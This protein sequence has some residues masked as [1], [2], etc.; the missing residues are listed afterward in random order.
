MHAV[1]HILPDFRR[2][3]LHPARP[4]EDLPVL[5]L[6]DGNDRRLIVEQ[7]AA[8]RGGALVDRRDKATGGRHGYWKATS[9]KL[10]SLRECR[11]SR[12]S[13]LSFSSAFSQIS[14]CWPTRCRSNS[15]AMPARLISRKETR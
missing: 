3:M 9:A 14:I 15:P 11:L 7:D 10:L 13:V 4:G 12:S 8:R 6:G 5:L 1:A 2:V